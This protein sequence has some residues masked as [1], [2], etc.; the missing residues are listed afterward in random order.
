MGVF[1]TT[2]DA[3][4][5]KTIEFV[6][7]RPEFLATVA[8]DLFELE[9][10]AE[11]ESLRPCARLNVFSDFVWESIAP[12]FFE[13]F[14]GIQFY[15]YTKGLARFRRF[16][17]GGL[18]DNYHLTFSRSEETPDSTVSELLA[19]GAIVSALG[20]EGAIQARFPEARILNGDMHDLTFLH[21]KGTLLAL[22]AKGKAKH[23]QTGF[24]IRENFGDQNCAECEVIIPNGKRYSGA[25]DWTVCPK[26][27]D[28]DYGVA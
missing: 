23:D 16:L 7:N 15:D 11:K 21:P 13:Y 4:V 10:R 19:E 14:R 1:Q 28:A 27:D 26:C 9:R 8:Q 6:E 5:R 3:R 18:P 25:P 12:V 24:V 22:S 20:S 2:Q 17:S